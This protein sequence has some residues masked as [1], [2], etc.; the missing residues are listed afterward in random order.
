[1]GR[2][3]VTVKTLPITKKQLTEYASEVVVSDR[4]A[5]QKVNSHL[6]HQDP[7]VLSLLPFSMVWKKVNIWRNFY[8]STTAYPVGSKLSF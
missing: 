5:V 2:Q 7:D 4:A 6:L 8:F 3:I 1:M